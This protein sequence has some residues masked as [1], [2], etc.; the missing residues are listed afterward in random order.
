MLVHPQLE[1]QSRM[2]L[3]NRLNAALLWP[4]APA[5]SIFIN[6]LNNLFFPHYLNT[7]KRVC[8]VTGWARDFQWGTDGNEQQPDS[9]KRGEK[10]QKAKGDCSYF[11]PAVVHMKMSMEKRQ[12]HST[13]RGTGNKVFMLGL[14]HAKLMAGL[15]CLARENW[16]WE[17][18]EEGGESRIWLESSNLQPNFT[19]RGCSHSGQ[20]AF[21][22]GRDLVE[23]MVNDASTQSYS[24]SETY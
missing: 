19:L 6:L 16:Y 4:H 17:E 2:L 10:R 23:V 21:Q 20:T 13:R 8:W 15:F 11:P 24:D 18:M 22:K 7:C 12:N 14:K 3:G 9:S 1:A 5:L